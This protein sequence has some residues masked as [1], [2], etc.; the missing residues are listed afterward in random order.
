MAAAT[1]IS[2][3]QCGTQND[4]VWFLRLSF[5][6]GKPKS[7]ENG[8]VK[9]CLHCRI[10]VGMKRAFKKLDQQT[11]SQKSAFAHLTEWGKNTVDS[12]IGVAA[13]LGINVNLVTHGASELRIPSCATCTGLT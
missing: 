4:S 11:H 12:V 1:K 13:E 2:C 10:P 6:S 7:A 5:E 3:N 9:G 8:Y